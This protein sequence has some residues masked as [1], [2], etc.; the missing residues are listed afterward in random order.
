MAVE[1]AVFDRQHRL[2]HVG[3]IA[4]SGTRRR[5]S[6]DVVTSALSSGG[7]SSTCGTGRVAGEQPLDARRPG[8]TPRRRPAGGAGGG[9]HSARSTCPANS[10]VRGTKTTAPGCGVNSPGPDGRARSE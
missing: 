4:V 8:R 7:S 6:R 5:R 3:G 2:L 9:A 1:A 10:P